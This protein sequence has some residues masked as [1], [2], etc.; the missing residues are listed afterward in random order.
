MDHPGLTQTTPL[1]TLSGE[2]YRAYRAGIERIQRRHSSH[3][4]VCD[5]QNSWAHVRVCMTTHTFFSFSDHE[6]IGLGG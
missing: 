4:A 5:F 3:C 2:E 6:F 1:R